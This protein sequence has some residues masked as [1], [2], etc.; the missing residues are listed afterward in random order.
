MNGVDL[1][2]VQALAGHKSIQMTMRYAHL[3]P[4]HLDAAIEKTTSP[5]ATTTA[6]EQHRSSDARATVLQ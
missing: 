4:S 1:R 3:A 5:T 6:T 2:T